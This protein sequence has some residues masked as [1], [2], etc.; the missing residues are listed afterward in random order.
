M[1][2][3]TSLNYFALKDEIENKGVKVTDIKRDS[4]NLVIYFNCTNCGEPYSIRHQNYVKGDNPKFLCKRCQALKGPKMQRI[5][6]YFDSMGVPILGVDF[7]DETGHSL[8]HWVIH[9]NCSRCGNHY[10]ILDDYVGKNNKELCCPNCRDN[11]TVPTQESVAK[12]FRNAGSELLSE[13]KNTHT[14]VKFRCTK[15]GGIGQISYSHFKRKE[16]NTNLY[17]DACL[18][19]VDLKSELYSILEEKG[20]KL[21][22][23]YVNIDTPVDVLCSR[24][25]K[26]FTFY[27]DNYRYSGFNNEI[28]CKSC[29]L[30]VM[31]SSDCYVGID[32]R[33]N[34]ID[35]FWLNYAVEFFN[36]YGDDRRLYAAHHINRYGTDLDRRTS[37]V[38]IFPLKQELHT[39]NNHFYHYE[40]GIDIN[41]WSGVEKLP[42]HNYDG[43]KF[44]D[45]N[46]KCI[47]EIIYPK[48][49]MSIKYLYNRKK[50]FADEGIFYMPFFFNE[51]RLKEQRALMFSMIRS[52]LY[53]WFPD[54][55]K[56]TGTE[57]KKYYARKLEVKR[58]PNLDA[59]KFFEL[60]HIQGFVNSQIYLGLYSLDG[61]L[62]SC[63]SFSKPRSGT[64]CDYEITRF[65]SQI[66]SLVVGGASKLFKS[67]IESFN[68]DSVVSF[69]DVRFSSINPN[70]TVYAKLGFDYDGY[71]DPNY[72]YRDP[73]T[74]MVRNRMSFQKAR[75]E[76]M[77]SDYDPNL[78]EF[79]NL[80]KHGFIRQVDCGNFR[81]IWRK[82]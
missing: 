79:Q 35:Q 41:N 80:E 26:P 19:K 60:N 63:M 82:K 78:T 47:T 18:G 38:N 67:F 25:K 30:D 9:F 49:S 15:C 37:F 59:S 31:R 28:L 5:Q 62:V 68:P 74:G 1:A 6:E 29:R 12:D 39:G 34:P 52:R 10:T 7:F 71:S 4:R 33:K 56:Y 51:I 61:D 22:G 27:Y 65:A 14:P 36:I 21:V 32:G 54:I 70:D 20:S 24:C 53:K 69:C 50:K 58:V 11:N 44:L 3:P 43:F 46:S 2:R 81:F 45:L 64:V 8:K 23:E 48:E 73:V 55:Y 40:E 75:L 17:C 13:Y 57:L 77:F 76:K 16:F 42:Y 66:N 72:G